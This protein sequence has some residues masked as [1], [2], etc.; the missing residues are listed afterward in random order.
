MKL[1][2]L[3]P[4]HG[5]IGDGVYWLMF[6]CFKC[7]PPHRIYL[8]FHRGEQRAGVWKCTSP[9]KVWEG[10]EHL[11]ETPDRSCLT[12]IPSFR[13]HTHGPKHPTCGL[14]A[15]ITAGEVKVDEG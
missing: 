8:Q 9:W 13:Y 3:H 1:A 2:D 12:L 6:D 15:T 4:E 10:L 5:H 14:H 7:G 11:G